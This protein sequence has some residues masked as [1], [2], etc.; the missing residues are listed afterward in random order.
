MI[1]WSQEK[2]HVGLNANGLLSDLRECDCMGQGWA[3]VE[4]GMSVSGLQ[5]G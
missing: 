4:A 3:V 1:G 2:G 5:S